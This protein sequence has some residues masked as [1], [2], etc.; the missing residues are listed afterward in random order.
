MTV[1]AYAIVRLDLSGSQGDAHVASLEALAASRR[2]QLA[3][4]G[5]LLAQSD[6]SFCQLL[7]GLDFEAVDVVMVP[8]AAQIKGW[9]GVLRHSAEVWTALLP[10]RWPRCR[11]MAS[12][13]AESVPRPM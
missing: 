9:L 11:V 8:S 2:V 5:V 7:A 1:H 3:A 10:Q 13:T 4:G 12:Q 6:S